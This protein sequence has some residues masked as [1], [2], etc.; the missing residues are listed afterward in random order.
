VHF[1]PINSFLSAPA[2]PDFVRRYGCLPHARG[3]KKTPANRLFRIENGGWYSRLLIANCGCLHRSRGFITT[4]AN[5]LHR[6][7]NKGR[8]GRRSIAKCAGLR[9][10]RSHG[11]TRVRSPPPQTTKPSRPMS[12]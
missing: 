6:I 9:R 11:K 8:S 1:S 5:R 7:D 12:S 3:Y 10:C 2:C 4:P